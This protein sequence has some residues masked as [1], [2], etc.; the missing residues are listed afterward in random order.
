MINSPAKRKLE[1]GTETPSMSQIWAHL[2]IPANT[3]KYLQIPANTCKYLQNLFLALPQSARLARLL[4][5][6]GCELPQSPKRDGQRGTL[7]GPFFLVGSW[8]NWKGW[9]GMAGEKGPKTGFLGTTV[10]YM[11]LSYLHH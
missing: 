7:A 6:G 1:T 10:Y 11:T 4:D 8:D 2:Q 5:V 9:M 3:C